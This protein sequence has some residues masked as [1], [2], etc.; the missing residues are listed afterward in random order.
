MTGPHLPARKYAK[1][2]IVKKI[3]ILPERNLSIF[4]M[5]E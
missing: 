2:T 4:K 3:L 5:A 1:V